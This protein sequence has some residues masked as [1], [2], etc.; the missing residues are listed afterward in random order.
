MSNIPKVGDRVVNVDVRS[1]H[2]GATGTVVDVMNGGA[3]ISVRRD[4]GTRGSGIYGTWTVRASSWDLIPEKPEVAEPVTGVADW[5]YA[6]AERL[7]QAA[8]E[9]MSVYNQY[10][11]RKPTV[12]YLQGST[13]TKW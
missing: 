12:N 11:E 6:E 5:S 3:G 8:V 4:D 13:P 2:F 10:I 7:Y 1:K 9:A